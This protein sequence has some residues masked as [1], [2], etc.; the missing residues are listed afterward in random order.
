MIGYTGLKTCNIGYKGENMQIGC[1]L[2][3]NANERDSIGINTLEDA[4]KAG[5]DYIE[6]PV[7]N[8][9][10]LDD[11]ARDAILK[12]VID[13]GLPCYSGNNLFPPG[14]KLLEDKT[15]YA[16][17]SEYLNRAL[18]YCKRLDMKV[19]VFGSGGARMRP[20]GMTLDQGHEKLEK[21]LHLMA[22][23]AEKFDITFVLETLRREE[24]NILNTMAET[25]KL[26]GAVS[27]PRIKM[28]CDNYHM[29]F[30]G[31]K[32]Q[33]DIVPVISD[34]KHAHFCRVKGRVIPNTEL[35]E[36]EKEY[37]LTLINNG[38]EG[39]LSVEAYSQDF[40]NDSEFIVKQLKSIT[41]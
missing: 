8:M 37:V 32:P 31:E 41:E 26:Q 39:N 19:L 14:I 23:L 34:I 6:L 12:K 28:L 17:I 27:H 22:G 3:M 33:S 35:L 29:S 11:G 18:D 9:M 16:A 13:A 24:S 20:D 40:I 15:S 21:L 30:A 36:D 25:R 1:C 38:Y 5:Y 2:S 10:A 4:I 7:S